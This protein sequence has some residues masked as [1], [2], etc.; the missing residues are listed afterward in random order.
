MN[1]TGHNKSGSVI[2]NLAIGYDPLGYDDLKIT[3]YVNNELLKGSGSLYRTN[4]DLNIWINSIKNKDFLSQKSY[5]KLLKNYGSNY[6]FGIS[7]YNSFGNA[8]F[9]HDGRVNGYIADYLHYEEEDISII[10]LGNIQTGVSDFFRSDIASILFNEDYKSRAKTIFPL[11]EW[12][13]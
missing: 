13:D 2:E 11:K 4:K 1:S 12:S 9:G 3:Y 7:V 6:G 5:E 8:V 10:I